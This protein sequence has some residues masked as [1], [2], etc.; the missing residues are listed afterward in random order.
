MRCPQ[1]SFE[2]QPRSARLL[3]PKM[4]IGPYNAYKS[5]VRISEPIQALWEKLNE[6]KHPRFSAGVFFSVSKNCCSLF[7]CRIFK[8]CVGADDSVRPQQIAA[9]TKPFW[10]IRIAFSCL[11]VGADA[12]I[13]PLGSCEFAEEYRK[14]AV[15]CRA[16]V[17]IGPYTEMSSPSRMCRSFSREKAAFRWADRVVRPYEADT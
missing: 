6:K 13:G 7:L 5:S 14:N 9:K 16:D 1:A 11:T 15:F 8:V 4:G 2:A 12:Y 3:A 17:G 10:R